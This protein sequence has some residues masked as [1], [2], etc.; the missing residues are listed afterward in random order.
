MTKGSYRS[1]LV[2]GAFWLGSVIAVGTVA[3]PAAAGAA[4]PVAAP[5]DRPAL[6]P[7]PLP[8]PSAV[9][10]AV[11]ISPAGVVVGTSQALPATGGGMQPPPPASGLR[12]LPRRGGY[13]EQPLAVPAGTTSVSVAGVTDLGEAGG[14]LSTPAGPEAVRWS[15]SGL[16]TISLG[17]AA[18]GPTTPNTITTTS[19]VGPG[20][21]AVS[22]GDSIS[23]STALVARDGTRTELSGTPDLDGARILAAYSIGGPSTALVGTISGVGYGSTGHTVVWRAGATVTLPVVSSFALGNTCASEIQPD[24]SVAYSGPVGSTSQGPTFG[25]GLHRGGVPGAE[26]PLPT[27][28]RTAT[29]GCPS[30]DTLAADGSVVG[31]LLPAGSQPGEAALW[32]GTTLVPLGVRAGELSTTAAAVATRGRVVLVATTST[33][34][35]VP[36]L[37]SGGIRTP[38]ALPAGWTLRN[39][40]EMTD[41]G[42]V[43]ANVRDA[44]G[45]VRPVVWFTGT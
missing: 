12:W 10:Q 22:T 14:T 13:V 20:Q 6:A 33:G 8:G 11:D 28:G 24:G 26:V 23:G 43:L 18:G 25:I 5:A 41:A 38:L 29:V 27:G 17:S 1:V 3:A 19:A 4:A 42:V 31:Q 21:W 36:Y 2:V 30:T 15:V 45:D 32:R 16:R 39:V 40:V 44:A 7:V 9:T 37:W 34:A 35:D